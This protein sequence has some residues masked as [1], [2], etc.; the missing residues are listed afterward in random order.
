M[1]AQIW[2][3]IYR[4][5]WKLYVLEVVTMISFKK[6]PRYLCMKGPESFDTL[7]HHSL[8][9]TICMA[10]STFKKSTAQSYAAFTHSKAEE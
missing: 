4:K 8:S 3:E 10:L 6:W 7:T 2:T 5:R 9:F 1:S